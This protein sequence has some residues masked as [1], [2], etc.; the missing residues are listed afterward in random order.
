MASAEARRRKWRLKWVL[1]SIIFLTP[2]L[3]AAVFVSRIYTTQDHQRERLIEACQRGNVLR[4]HVQTLEELHADVL[5]TDYAT[6]APFPC[7][8]L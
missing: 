4:A 3:L 1:P 8:E 2:M 7:E 6:L 5:P